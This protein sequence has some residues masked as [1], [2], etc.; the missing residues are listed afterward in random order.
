MHTSGLVKT[1]SD[2]YT[3][4]ALSRYSGNY[5][6]RALSPTPVRPRRAWRVVKSGAA[7]A[8]DERFPLP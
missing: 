2:K 5:R 7:I 3:L 6:S 1:F 8:Y 4:C